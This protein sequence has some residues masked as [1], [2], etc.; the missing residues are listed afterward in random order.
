LVG[1]GAV[2]FCQRF[3]DIF[4]NLVVEF[5]HCPVVSFKSISLIVGIGNGRMGRTARAG[6]QNH[7]GQDRGEKHSFLHGNPF[8]K[9][10]GY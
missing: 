10:A 3:E 6:Y 5:E 7:D 8:L 9:A 4:V 1:N 2:A